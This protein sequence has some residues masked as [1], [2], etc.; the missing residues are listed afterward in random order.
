MGLD[1][2]ELVIE[3]EDSFGLTIPDHAAVKM[4]SPGDIFDYIAATR[5]SL[6]AQG[7]LMQPLF[8]DLKRAIVSEFTVDPRK[9]R[10]K[11]SIVELI[12]DYRTRARRSRVIERL[13]LPRPPEVNFGWF[14]LRKDFGTFGHLATDLL[15]RNYGEL[16]R[17]LEKWHS[18]EVWN[19]LRHLISRQLGVPVEKVTR[20]AHFVNDLGLS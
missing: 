1:G 17:R 5:F 10:P 2:V 15:T 11:S 8:H 13:A 7:P 9:V 4:E 20:G 18:R 14:G 3:V 16:S 19:C 6:V 12:P